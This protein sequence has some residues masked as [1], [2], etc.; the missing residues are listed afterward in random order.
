VKIVVDSMD[1]R[2]GIQ[3][4]SIEELSGNVMTKLTIKK[5]SARLLILKLKKYK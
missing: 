1:K 3:I 2:Y 4:A 5:I